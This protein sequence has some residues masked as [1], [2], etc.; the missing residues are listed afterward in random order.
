MRRRCVTV[1]TLSLFN[2]LFFSSFRLLFVCCFLPHCVHSLCALRDSIF[3][4]LWLFMSSLSHLSLGSD[5]SPPPPSIIVIHRMRI[6]V[7]YG[8]IENTCDCDCKESPPPSDSQTSHC[9]YHSI[10]LS[11]TLFSARPTQPTDRLNIAW[12][13]KKKKNTSVRPSRTAEQ[14]NEFFQP[15]LFPTP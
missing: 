5:R 3:Y 15:N 4:F 10:Q 14:L 7:A 9:V 8:Q 11:I 13:Q 2:F 1:T 6:S 12:K